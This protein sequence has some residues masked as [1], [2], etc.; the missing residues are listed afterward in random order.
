[1]IFTTDGLNDLGIIETKLMRM[2]LTMVLL[3]IICTAAG[4]TRIASA[5][6]CKE[7]SE[8]EVVLLTRSVNFSIP[9]DPDEIFPDDDASVAHFFVRFGEPLALKDFIILDAKAIRLLECL[10]DCVYIAA[11]TEAS[12]TSFVGEHPEIDVRLAAS[13]EPQDKIS[14]NI[15]HGKYETWAINPDRTLLKVLI[16]LHQDVTREQAD[17]ALDGVPGIVTAERYGSTAWACVVEIARIEDIA[18]L[19]PVR[20]IEQGPIEPAP[21]NGT[22]RPMVGTEGIQYPDFTGAVPTYRFDG[23]DVQIGICD[24]GVLDSH[25]DFAD[26]VVS[27]TGSVSLGS[28]R[29]TS[30]SS[31]W[32]EHGTHVAGVAAGSGFLSEEFDLPGFHLRGHAPGADILDFNLYVLGTS[33]HQFYE[34][35]VGHGAD[36]T[37]HSHEQSTDGYIGQVAEIDRIV[38]GDGQSVTG[39]SVP[40]RPQVWGAGNQG[41]SVGYHSLVAPA[42]NSITVGS[43]DSVDE[44]LTRKSSLGPTLDGRIKP[45]LVAPGCRDSYVTGTGEG[46]RSAGYDVID[47]EIHPD[48]GGYCG[49]STAAPVVSA[50]VALMMQ[51]ASSPAGEIEHLHPSTYKA[52][53]VNTAKDMVKSAPYDDDREIEYPD[54]GGPIIYHAGPDFATGFG[55]VDARAA[56]DIVDKPAQWRESTVSAAYPVHRWCLRVPPGSG[57]LKVTLAWDDEPG[58]TAEPQEFS[59]LTN[60]LDLRLVSPFGGEVLPWTV[61]PSPNTVDAVTGVSTINRAVRGSDRFN[62]VEKAGKCAPEPGIW[63]VEVDAGNRLCLGNSQPYSLVATHK[64]FGVCPWMILCEIYPG[65]CQLTDPVKVD[66]QPL[67]ASVIPGAPVARYVGPNSVLSLRELCRHGFDCPRC[68]GMS[69]IECPGLELFFDGVP[70]DARMVVFDQDGAI[71]QDFEMPLIPETRRELTVDLLQPGRE[72]FVGFLDASNQPYSQGFELA[73]DIRRLVHPQ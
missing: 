15:Q 30:V 36:V 26:I 48:Y 12:W 22:V 65:F 42:K 53:L 64:F 7:W 63:R 49:T 40:A 10:Q 52:M 61:G 67:A 70:E 17:S 3:A 20:R 73:F 27:D 59:K 28:S 62:N 11:S 35:I 68:E 9:V 46:I 14:L 29:V 69:W 58:C 56:L 23:T 13:I 41:W 8:A 33:D 19:D 1:M 51:K 71:V 72:I 6:D 47:G 4:D 57:E 54:T 38:R 66:V 43:I 21:L 18:A 16:F 37:N 39:E 34:A 44:R 5:Q 50:I 60:D 24:F 2:V 31:G 25:P 32:H 55:L 45:D